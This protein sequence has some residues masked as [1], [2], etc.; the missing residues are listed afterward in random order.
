M[1]LVHISE[2]SDC[3]MFNTESVLH[4]QFSPRVKIRLI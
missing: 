3:R 2:P 1:L 4:F